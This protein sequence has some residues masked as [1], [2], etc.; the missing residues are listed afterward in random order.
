[1]NTVIVR[2]KDGDVITYINVYRVLALADGYI[3]FISDVVNTV[4]ISISN[5]VSIS[6]E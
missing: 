4:D 6:V 3:L 1:M 5:V 2:F